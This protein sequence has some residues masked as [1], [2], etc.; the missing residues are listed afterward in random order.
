MS[1]TNQNRYF[2]LS[3]SICDW[4][5]YHNDFMGYRANHPNP[6]FLKKD[7]PKTVSEAKGALAIIDWQE[8]KICARISLPMP[9]GICLLDEQLIITLRGTHEL[10][11]LSKTHSDYFSNPHFGNLHT[12]HPSSGGIL[13]TS[14]ATDTIFELNDKKEIIW[15]WS[16]FTHGLTALKNGSTYRFDSQRDNRNYVSIAADHPAHINAAL[17]ISDGSI[18]A[19]CF[20]Q[21]TLIQIDKATG[22][23]KVLLEG[24]RYPHA[25]QKRQNGFLLSDSLSSRILLLDDSFQ[26]VKTLTKDIQWVQEAKEIANQKII[27]LSN[28]NIASPNPNDS[29]QILIFDSSGDINDR[30]KWD[31]NEHLFDILPL[32]STQADYWIEAWT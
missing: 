31:P 21:G 20:H 24:L 18:L 28:R 19:T 4:E 13:V 26:L 30:W 23:W 15:S 32:T 16:G 29:N 3:I 12:I 2:L 5:K 1:N 22:N 17:E 8:K 25:I 27:A 9:Q 7:L 14:S 11:F 10:L 6:P